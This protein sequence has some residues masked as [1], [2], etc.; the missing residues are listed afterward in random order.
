MSN[1]CHLTHPTEIVLM[2]HQAHT[3]SENTLAPAAMCVNMYEHACGSQGV[4]SQCY[5]S[6]TVPH[7]SFSPFPLSQAVSFSWSGVA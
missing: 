6:G 5:F 3:Q 1:G 4:I 7:N 2:R